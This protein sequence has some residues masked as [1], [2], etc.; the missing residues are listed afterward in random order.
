MSILSIEV[1]VRDIQI[2]D[3]VLGATV[4]FRG[5]NYRTDS[6]GLATLYYQGSDYGTTVPLEV[7]APGFA[8]YRGLIAL[9]STLPT[10]LLVNLTPSGTRL[11]VIVLDAITKAPIVGAKVFINTDEARV[12]GSNGSIEAPVGVGSHTVKVTALDYIG[13]TVTTSQ[14]V[15]ISLQ[16]AIP[17]RFNLQL[18]FEPSVGDPAPTEGAL[19]AIS[20]G[21]ITENPLTDKNGTVVTA[22]TFFVGQTVTVVVSKAGFDTLNGSLIVKDTGPYR[23]TLIKSDALDDTPADSGTSASDGS[24]LASLVVNPETSSVSWKRPDEYEWIYPTG[25]FGKYFSTTQARMYIGNVFVDELNTVQFALQANRI[26]VYGYAS[27]DFDAVGIGKALVQGQIMVNFI[28]EGYLYTILKEHDRLLR[29]RRL[30]DDQKLQDQERLQ[31]LYQNK[32]SLIAQLGS[33]GRNVQSPFGHQTLASL[34]PEEEQ[35]L[36]RGRPEI[37]HAINTLDAEIQSIA[38]RGSGVFDRVQLKSFDTPPETFLN[39]VYLPIPFAIEF[40]MEGAGR[41]VKRKLEQCYLGANE[42]IMDQS[43]NGLV[44][45]YSFIARRMR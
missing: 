31:Q 34:T 24:G 10:T 8:P 4:S 16:P 9:L 45:T 37:E 29:E 40:E 36:V 12:T 44:D 1:L 2:Q 20:S 38:A 39:A 23:F 17:Q 5:R 30:E 18:V 21:S 22:N 35:L 28:S 15:T 26:P 3:R 42:Q 33:G 7:I 27:R 13:Q 43:G 14:A 41:K 11:P 25:E 19:V 6:N 32:R